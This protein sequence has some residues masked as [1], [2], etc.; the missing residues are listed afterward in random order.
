MTK[1]VKPWELV[2][3]S[4]KSARGLQSRDVLACFLEIR[5]ALLHK[6]PELT[7][8]VLS[9]GTNEINN[10]ESHNDEDI[11]GFV[12]RQTGYLPGLT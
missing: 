5:D 8:A 9:T 10:A 1:V 2:I 11:K 7:A 12:Q 6:F 4:A 3:E